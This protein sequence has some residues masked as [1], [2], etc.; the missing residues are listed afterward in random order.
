MLKCRLVI[1]F[2]SMLAIAAC[3]SP[4]KKLVDKKC[5]DCH[6]LSVVYDKNYSE[7]QWRNTVTAMVVR[8]LKSTPEENDIIVQ[9][10]TKEHGHE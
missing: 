8:G 2:V 3:A 1:V 4:E 10:L 7:N 6:T 9:Y 5:D